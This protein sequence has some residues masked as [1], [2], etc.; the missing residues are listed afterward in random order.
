METAAQA[1]CKCGGG[2][3]YERVHSSCGAFISCDYQGGGR[4]VCEEGFAGTGC[5]ETTSTVRLSST[6]FSLLEPVSGGAQNTLLIV[7]IVRTISAVPVDAL[8]IVEAAQS[9]RDSLQACEDR[10]SFAHYELLPP[11][12]SITWINETHGFISCRLRLWHDEVYNPAK[13][14]V[15]RLG[16]HPLLFRDSV[17]AS[18]LEAVVTIRD[19]APGTVQF[20]QSVYSGIEGNGSVFV[21]LERV[22]GSASI[23]EAT[24]RLDVF[25]STAVLNA[26][27]IFS[28]SRVVWADGDVRPKAVVVQLLQDA[29]YET[30]NERVVLVVSSVGHPDMRGSTLQRTTI[31]ILDDGDAG[32]LASV[33]LTYE[34]RR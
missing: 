14:V 16:H 30:P 5:N 4:C 23:V 29:Q 32:I 20:A 31:T 6:S 17:I 12:D 13:S 24:I 2:D 33:L 15:L 1:C 28:E 21:E 19:E 7:P 8:V 10:N 9:Y 3:T 22:G 26:D 11:F 34:R 25:T 27:F 18:P